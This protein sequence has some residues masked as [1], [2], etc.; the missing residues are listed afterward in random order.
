MNIVATPPDVRRVISDQNTPVTLRLGPALVD[1]SNDKENIPPTIHALVME[2]IQ[3]QECF[4]SGITQSNVP[5]PALLPINLQPHGDISPENTTLIGDKYANCFSNLDSK[6]LVQIFDCAVIQT[7]TNRIISGEITVRRRC[8]FLMI[9]SN[10]VF[11]ATKTVVQNELKM[12]ILCILGKNP[13][14]KVFVSGVMPRPAKDQYAKNYIRDFNRRLSGTVK[15]IQKEVTRVFYIP[16]QLQFMVKEEYSYL[17][18]Q[19]LLTLN[20]FG[21]MH[22]KWV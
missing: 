20:A 15:K 13:V 21:K 12:L 10:Q 4:S 2:E 22:L 19:D 6:W 18:Q 1:L 14:A 8:I 3:D 7:I 16:V 5:P 9:S 11:R 17:F